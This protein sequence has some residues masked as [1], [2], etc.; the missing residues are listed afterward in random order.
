MM[1]RTFT[2]RDYLDALREAQ[3]LALLGDVIYVA[4]RTWVCYYV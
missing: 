2:A 3:R 1:A 4:P